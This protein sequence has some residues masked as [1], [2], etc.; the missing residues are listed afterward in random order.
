MGLGQILFH[1]MPSMSLKSHFN[2]EYMSENKQ[3]GGQ[4]GWPAGWHAPMKDTDSALFCLDG[5]SYFFAPWSLQK[6]A[7]NM[8]GHTASHRC[9]ALAYLAWRVASSICFSVSSPTSISPSQFKDNH[10]YQPPDLGTS[11]APSDVN[12]YADSSQVGQL[13]LISHDYPKSGQ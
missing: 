11:S 7:P 3:E 10:V 8:Q 4:V 2:N 5:P 12:I 1:R 6:S 9:P 13:W